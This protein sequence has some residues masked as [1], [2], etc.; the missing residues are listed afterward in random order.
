MSF[1]AFSA[2]VD[3]VYRNERKNQLGVMKLMMCAG[4][5]LIKNGPN[6]CVS[7]ELSFAERLGNSSRAHAKF[8]QQRNGRLLSSPTLL[9][10]NKKRAQIQALTK[11][12]TFLRCLFWENQ[13]SLIHS[14]IFKLR[15][16][17]YGS[18]GKTRLKDFQSIS[19]PRI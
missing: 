7:H 15:L 17:K 4:G 16:L 13:F 8:M 10:Q 3:V 11:H 2:F 1:C 6:V 18:K 12:P 5:S 19:T 9:S 14:F